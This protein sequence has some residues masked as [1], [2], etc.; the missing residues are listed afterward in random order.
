MLT[1]HLNDTVWTSSA[2]AMNTEFTRAYIYFDKSELDMETIN[3]SKDI[4]SSNLV[5]NNDTS[6]WEIV[7]MDRI[8]FKESIQPVVIGEITNNERRFLVRL[9]AEFDNGEKAQ[10]APPGFVVTEDGSTLMAVQFLGYPER[11]PVIWID[12]GLDHHTRFVLITAASSL[13]SRLVEVNNLR[14]MD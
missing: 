8:R 11:L 14:D 13:I 7:V 1:D 2:I 4:Y 5:F 9:V 3:K 12:P 6:K 10:F